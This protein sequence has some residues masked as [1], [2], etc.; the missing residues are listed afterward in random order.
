M[1]LTYGRAKGG[2]PLDSTK[3][4][5][6]VSCGHSRL[7]AGFAVVLLVVS[8]T[9]AAGAT[10]RPPVIERRT[11][12]RVRT[13]PVAGEKQKQAERLERDGRALE[14]AD[15]YGELLREDPVLNKALVHRLVKIYADEGKTAE[16]LKWAKVAAGD[17]P[18]PQ[19]MMAGVHSMLGDHATAVRLL[20]RELKN[21]A[22]SR[23]RLT[24]HWQLAAVYEKMGATGMAVKHLRHAVDAAEA[25]PFKAAAERRL[26]A[27]LKAVQMTPGVAQPDRQAP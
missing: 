6:L 24:L 11:P 21:E 19:A 3:Q 13:T 15:I 18:D 26:A 5:P 2:N 22:R 23:R 8:C 10:N 4:V 1:E 27:F 7:R 14:A 20:Q 12:P 9:H 25:P 17:H 16:A